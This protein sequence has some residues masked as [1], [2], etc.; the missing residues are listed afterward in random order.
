[1]AEEQ[2]EGETSGS[3]NGV[4]TS[5][6]GHSDAMA[7]FLA[8]RAAAEAPVEKKSATREVADDDS[9]LDEDDDNSTDDDADEVDADVTEDKDDPDADLDEDEDPTE[10][11]DDEKDDATAKGIDKVRRTEKR[12]REGLEKQAASARADLDERV[13]QADRDLHE[14]WGSRI[15]KAEQFEKHA[16]R[17]NVDALGVL[18][19]LGFKEENYEALAQVMY[20]MAKAKDDPKAK[21]A[22]ASL[23]KDRERDHEIAE[24]KRQWA[25]REKADKERESQ[26]A[27]DRKWDAYFDRVT[28]AA[29]DKTPLAAA[30]LKANPDGARERMHV[31]TAKLAREAGGKVPSERAVMVALEKDRRRTLRELGIDPTTRSAVAA[32][33]KVAADAK[34]KP[35]T[36]KPG[37]KKSAKAP[38]NTEKPKPFT[39]DDFINRKFD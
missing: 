28:K 35:A 1:M 18:Q 31:L 33:G 16:S 5:L 34:A 38:T 22:V 26:T 9:D 13:R 21:A 36:T 19:S 29:S 37:D 24:M 39:K 23:M 2:S 25:E 6:H 12:M 3:T 4:S 10:D 11:E 30:W 27:E 32:S 15:E 8:V 14:K 17:V 7:E 20:T